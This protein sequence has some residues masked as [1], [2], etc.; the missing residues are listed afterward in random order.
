VSRVLKRPRRG[1]GKRSLADRFW[2]SVAGGMLWCLMICFVSAVFISMVGSTIK[3]VEDVIYYYENF[4][5]VEEYNERREK[6]F[7]SE[8]SDTHI[9][10]A[11]RRP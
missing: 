6:E 3:V 11:P 4:E 8:L 2:D 7:Q 10:S 5:T 1:W 9:Q